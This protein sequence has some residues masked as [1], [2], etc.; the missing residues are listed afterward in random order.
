[1]AT[2][3][4]ISIDQSGQ[5]DSA[6]KLI[7]LVR[8]WELRSGVR[9]ALPGD[10]TEYDLRQPDFLEGLLPFHDH[11]IYQNSEVETKQRVLSCGWLAFNAKA[12]DIE[13]NI[14]NFA[15][16][17]LSD[18]MGSQGFTPAHRDLITQTLVDEA[19]HVYIMDKAMD[20]TRAE[21][22]LHD[23]SLPASGMLSFLRA[24]QRHHSLDWQKNMA[25][26]CAAFATE[27]FIVGHL[28]RL[29]KTTEPL[30]PLNLATTMAHLQDE[31]VHESVFRNVAVHYYRSLDLARREFF[32]L[33]M[34]KA[35]VWFTAEDW[36][37]WNSVLSQIGLEPNRMLDEVRSEFVTEV[38][39]QPLAKFLGF[40]GVEDIEDSI[41]RACSEFDFRISVRL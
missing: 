34:V 10:S 39:F 12:C 20:V 2:T 13:R 30:Q 8:R 15:C 6:S 16:V 41:A 7:S 25:V 38:E 29:A 22:G 11:P 23:L 14:V 32:L 33:T 27:I 31:A 21:R 28:S 9:S 26:I 3:S 36:N 35:V 19:F 37:C 40:L 24:H 17:Q 18:L 5:M 1:M 4:N